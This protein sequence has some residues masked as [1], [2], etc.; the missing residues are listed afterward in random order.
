MNRAV[1]VDVNLGAGFSDDAFDGFAAG[2][3]ERADFLGIDLDRLDARR[4]FAEIGARFVD[5]LRHDLENFRARFFRAHGRFGHDFM[6]DAGQFEIELESGDARFR[7]ANFVIHV[8]EM[9]F[10]AD[11]IGEQLVAFQ[12]GRPRHF[13]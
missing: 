3:D 1:V 8:S 9:I 13:P 12:S 2:S 6:A 10:G 4:V 5:R 11:D 7:S